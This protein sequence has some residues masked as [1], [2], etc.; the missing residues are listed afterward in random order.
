MTESV[1]NPAVYYRNNVA[2]TLALL[3]AMREVGL[4][5]IV[6]SSTSAVYGEPA[7]LP[8]TSAPGPEFVS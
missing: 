2:G 8:V 7:R 3:D 6:F 1:E 4:G 5:K